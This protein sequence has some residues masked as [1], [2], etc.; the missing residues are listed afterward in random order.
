MEQTISPIHLANSHKLYRL[1][2]ETFVSLWKAYSAQFVESHEWE[3]L[4][5][6]N[7][8]WTNTFLGKTPCNVGEFFL[9]YFKDGNIPFRFWREDGTFDLSF[10]FAND[11]NNVA[12]TYRGETDYFEPTGYP[13]AYDV[14]I[15]IENSLQ[16]CWQEMT[17]MTW[18]RCPLKVVVTYNTFDTLKANEDKML[19]ERF[20]SIVAQSNSYFEDNPNTE[21]L[22]LIGYKR[23]NK[24]M[25]DAHVFNHDG[26]P[27]VS[28]V[29]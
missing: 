27:K 23:D 10:S 12:Y 17:K 9:N 2:A 19:L 11:F 16:A 20:S 15:E 6:S 3:S 24:L 13:I 21:Y 29:S 18:V 26:K 7:R 8:D 28:I 22:L 1:D 14:V 4:Y 25:W 5:D